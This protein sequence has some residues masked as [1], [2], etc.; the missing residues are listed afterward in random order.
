[1][2]AADCGTLDA[3][4]AGSPRIRVKSGEAP[5]GVH[6]DVWHAEEATFASTIAAESTGLFELEGIPPGTVYL[7]VQSETHPVLQLEALQI[8]EEEH[9]DL[10]V[11][12]LAPPASIH[13]NTWG[14]SGATE[15]ELV[16]LCT[17]L[18]EDML[19]ETGLVGAE[20]RGSSF[21]S[22]PLTAGR[23]AVCASA[24]GWWAPPVELSLNE[25]ESKAIELHGNH[26]SSRSIVFEPQQSKRTP[27]TLRV[28]ILDGA[29]RLVWVSPELE[30]RDGDFQVEVALPTGT[31]AVHA[32]TN[33]E[34]Q[35]RGQLLIDSQTNAGPLR[36]KLLR[37]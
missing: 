37:L 22:G 17:R 34:L 7:T 20:T 16:V 5:R 24:P 33:N 2:S 8:E 31:Y 14:L 27:R 10:G 21:Q 28:R 3:A 9:V 35:A 6:V 26:V 15:K 11:I 23:Y 32:M 18:D 29:E 12:R 30:P 1:M 25:G 19:D 36:L 13:G 4:T